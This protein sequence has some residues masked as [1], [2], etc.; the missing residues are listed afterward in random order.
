METT[1]IQERNKQIAL[2]LGWKNLNDDSFP[3]FINTFG[4]FY[5]LK[6]L[7]FD[8]DWNWL[9]EAVEFIKKNIRLSSN[10]SDAK[11]GE[12]F[13]DECEF[14]VKK[15]YIRLIQWTGTGWKMFDKEHK[16][17]SIFYIIGVNCQSEKEAIFL[18]VS[19]FAKLYNNKEL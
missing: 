10:T 8:S 6:N 9:M 16:D 12:Y 2:M 14:N 3:E 7:K 13:I 4:D 1:E 11:V 5:P 17:L 18:A 19:N 15:F